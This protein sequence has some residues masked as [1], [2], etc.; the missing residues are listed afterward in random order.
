MQIPLPK[1]STF[2]WTLLPEQLD[3]QPDEQE[4]G[5]IILPRVSTPIT[6]EARFA[7]GNNKQGPVIN[8]RNDKLQCAYDSPE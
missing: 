3:Y 7:S 8:Y 5:N 1:Q 2:R 4:G 6:L